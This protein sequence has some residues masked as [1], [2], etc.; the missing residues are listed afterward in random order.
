VRTF[1]GFSFHSP[2]SQ[3]AYQIEFLHFEGTFWLAGIRSKLSTTNFFLRHE[4]FSGLGFALSQAYSESV[5]S[6]LWCRLA[7]SP[8]QANLGFLQ[9][10]LLF[11]LSL[12]GFA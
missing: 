10:E 1:S 3:S 8:F 4:E 11:L 6:L 7:S 2:Q 5:T 9:H 12:F